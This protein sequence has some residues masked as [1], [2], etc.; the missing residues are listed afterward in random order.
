ML[1]CTENNFEVYSIPGIEFLQN[2]ILLKSQVDLTNVTALNFIRPTELI[3]V[4]LFL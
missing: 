1:P 4:L 2:K 3:I